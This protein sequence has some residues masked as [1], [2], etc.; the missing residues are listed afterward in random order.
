MTGKAMK[1]A[2]LYSL[3]MIAAQVAGFAI[4]SFV[5]ARTDWLNDVWSWEPSSRAFFLAA[6]AWLCVVGCLAV[7]SQKSS[8]L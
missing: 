4:G 8:Q 3:G 1:N 7:F 2:L 5:L 6:V